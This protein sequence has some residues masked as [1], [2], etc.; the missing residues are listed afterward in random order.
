[1]K[2]IALAL[3]GLGL[4][5]LLRRGRPDHRRVVVGWADGSELEPAEGTQERDRLVAVAE[6]V[7]G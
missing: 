4:W 7:L 3:A 5:A 2:I 6:G 1:M